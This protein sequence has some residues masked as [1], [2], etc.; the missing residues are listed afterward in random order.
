[1][2]LQ[3]VKEGFH[4]E[5]WLL[6]ILKWVLTGDEWKTL[7]KEA[8]ETPSRA[9]TSLC[10]VMWEAGQLDHSCLAFPSDGDANKFCPLR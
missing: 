10:P 6:L 7:G 8:P 4:S 5:T 2:R 9:W 3:A 1:M